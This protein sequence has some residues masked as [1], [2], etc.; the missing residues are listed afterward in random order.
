MKPTAP[1]SRAVGTSEPSE[2]VTE[3]ARSFAS[4]RGQAARALFAGI[5]TGGLVSTVRYLSGLPTVRVELSDGPAGREIKE[6]LGRR[7]AGIP[8]GRL[9]QGVLSLPDTVEDYLAGGQRR[10]LRRNLIAA[11][12]LG[13]TAWRVADGEALRAAATTVL[14]RRGV[15][16]ASLGTLLAKGRVG[17]GWG[18]VAT[19]ADG[20]PLAFASWTVD[21]RAAMLNTQTSVASGKDSCLARYALHMAVVRDLVR[22]RVPVMLADTAL[23]IG[24][25]HRYYQSLLGYEIVNMRLASHDRPVVAPQRIHP[26]PLLNVVAS[27]LPPAA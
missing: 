8:T 9:G 11:D 12:K 26:R 7:T 27:A 1:S 10:A 3:F 18:Y 13:I 21:E 19:G 15:D 6:A 23:T 2:K 14:L 24:A 20:D 16:P 17:D 22:A 4:A 5:R 25:G